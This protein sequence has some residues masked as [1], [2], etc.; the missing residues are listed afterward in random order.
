MIKIQISLF[1][2]LL[3]L[4]HLRKKMRFLLQ[5]AVME[6]KF[7]KAYL[8][9]KSSGNNAFSDKQILFRQASQLQYKF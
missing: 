5:K 8:H 1:Q 2:V 4:D 3:F 7:T 9:E 6:V